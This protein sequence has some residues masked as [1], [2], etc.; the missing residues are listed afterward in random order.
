MLTD[1]VRGSLHDTQ[2]MVILYSMKEHYKTKFLYYVYF[3]FAQTS[4]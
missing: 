1:L 4:G 3:C 2:V